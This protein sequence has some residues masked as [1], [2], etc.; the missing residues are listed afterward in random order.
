MM[1]FLLI[2]LLFLLAVTI[3]G[4]V[5]DVVAHMKLRKEWKRLDKE[6]K[7]TYEEIKNYDSFDTDSELTLKKDIDR[8]HT[9]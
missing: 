3:V 9:K 2:W 1:P 7:R 5:W 8:R 4:F 6:W